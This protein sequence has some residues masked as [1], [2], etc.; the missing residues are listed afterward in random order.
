MRGVSAGARSRSLEVMLSWWL[1]SR[2]LPR[3]LAATFHLHVLKQSTVLELFLQKIL[4]DPQTMPCHE[5]DLGA[6]A[7][8]V[9]SD[10][11]V[12]RVRCV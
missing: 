6:W 3:V 12:Q 7:T 2:V 9:D 4:C 11:P 10:P 1:R 8:Y 5:A